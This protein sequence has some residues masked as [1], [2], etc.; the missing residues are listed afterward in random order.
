VPAQQKSN[1]SARYLELFEPPYLAT[2]HYFQTNRCIKQ[3]G[4]LWISSFESGFSEQ[5]CTTTV[6]GATN[7]QSV[8][9]RGAKVIDLIL[10]V[11]WESA[12][13]PGC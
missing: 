11:C 2:C 5:L 8:I 9:P 3:L 4:T 7:L 13:F 12:S 6:D 1:I 10:K